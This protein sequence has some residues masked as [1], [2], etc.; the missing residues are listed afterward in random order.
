LSSDANILSRD[1]KHFVA[2]RKTFCRATQNI[3]SRDTKFVIC[4]KQTFIWVSGAKANAWA[5]YP[6]TKGKAEEA[7][8]NLGFE[9]TSVYRPGGI[10]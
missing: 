10:S 3:L 6:Q 7:V 9:R 2:L 5:L 1:A 4:V 8:R